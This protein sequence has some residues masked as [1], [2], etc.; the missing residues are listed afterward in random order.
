[1]TVQSKITYEPGRRLGYQG[2]RRVF[3]PSA[4]CE[5]FARWDHFNILQLNIAGIQNKTEEL[6]KALIDNDIRVALIQ[7]TILPKTKS[8]RI[9]GYT[10]YDCKCNNKCQ[11]IMTFIRNDT[12]AEVENIF[13]SDI[14]IQKVTA[15]LDNTKYTFY[16]IYWPN[17]ST[18]RLP[19]VETTFKRCIIAGDLNAHLPLLGY[20]DYNFRGREIED[21]LNSSNLILE[22]NM[23][24]TP[25]LLHKRHL[26]TSRPDLTILSADIYEKSTI[27]VL[28]SI[29][30]DHLPILTKLIRKNKPDSQR[31]TFWNYRKAKWNNYARIADE[32]FSKIDISNKPTDEVSTDICQAIL[33]AAKKAIPQGSFKKYKPFWS[34]DLS[35]AINARKQA[36]KAVAKDP[37]PKNRTNYNKY[38]AKVRNLTKSGKRMKWRNTCSK[39]DF[40]KNGKKAWRLLHNLEGSKRKEN[41][42][43]LSSDD[44]KISN[45]KEKANH[46]NKYL[47]GVSK[48]VRRRNLDKALWSLHKQKQ[49]APSCNNQAFEKDFTVQELNSAIKK[50]APRKAPGPDKIT[51]EM[52]SHLGSIAKKRL[53]QY[54]NRTWNE[55]QLPRSWKTARITPILKKGKPAGKPQ[56]YRPISLTSCLGKVTERMI[57]TRL[58]HW[59]EKNKILNETQAGFRRNSRTEDQLFRFV[60]S[61]IDGFQ[62]SKHTSAVFIDL[63]QAYDRVWRKG[64]LMK[65]GNMGIH[66]KMLK[67]IHAFLTNRTIQ[68]SMDGA[69]SSQLTLEEGL[70]QGSALSCTL[71]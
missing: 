4:P 12:Q 69:T 53:L 15:W 44:K 46:L 22:Q 32:E 41:P 48:S 36:R 65:M 1:M 39:L 47:A 24:S 68:T 59:L 52:I 23:E 64:L 70:P 40:N 57:N 5:K 55:G 8:I 28:D 14:D 61:T 58:Y 11:G 10:S 45:G 37:N 19:L 30:S 31:K 49:K 56:S 29:G 6:N 62:Q 54:I 71:F 17:S 35:A 16:N 18:T 20:H 66:G 7:E 13:S 51:N 34:K 63:Q 27:E 25:T 9:P 50:A 2:P 26:T 38:T 42:K 21:L 3:Q 67:W 43:P 60:Q 33:T